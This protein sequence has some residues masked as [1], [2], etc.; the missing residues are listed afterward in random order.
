[1]AL[2]VRRVEG[3]VKKWGGPGEKKNQEK[4]IVTESRALLA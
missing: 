3:S 4:T 2:G 1:M